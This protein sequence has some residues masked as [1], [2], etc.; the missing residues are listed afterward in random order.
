MSSPYSLKKLWSDK[1]IAAR[2]YLQFIELMD[3]VNW[4]DTTEPSK[5][6]RDEVFK[7]LFSV[8]HKLTHVKYHM[9][10][11]KQLEKTKF[12]EAK[13]RFRKHKAG[14]AVDIHEEF[15]MTAEVEAF[16]YQVKSSLD[17]MAKTLIYTVGLSRGAATTYGKKGN[18]VISKLKNTEAYRNTG[19]RPHIDNLI[20]LIESDRDNWLSPV[21]ALRDTVSHHKGVKNLV[22]NAMKLAGGKIAP[23][24]P[25]INGQAI[26]EFMQIIYDNLITFL[27]DFMALS[28]RV[29]FIPGLLLIQVPPEHGEKKY[30]V[31]QGRFVKWSIGAN[32]P[33]K[34]NKDVN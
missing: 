23:V 4:G 19:K 22:F 8:M 17:M 11:Y 3:A 24:H 27:Q 33:K 16:L 14:M 28:L 12:N 26:S 20:G 18:K 15:E 31:P 1:E 30:E 7:V 6:E 2:I 34:E 10:N 9:K 29:R 25:T 21:V 5:E 13:N 32:I